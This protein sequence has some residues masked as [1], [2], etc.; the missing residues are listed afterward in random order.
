[1]PPVFQPSE[2]FQ[3]DWSEDFAILGDERAKLQVAH[4]KLSR[5][6][7]FLLRAYPLQ[8]L[9]TLFDAHVHGFKVFDGV[10]ARGLND[11]L[12]TAKDR[13]GRGK[14][15]QVN[16]RFLAMAMLHWSEHAGASI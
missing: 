4:F 10:P 7:A 15:R 8:T 9:E 11:K 13:V 16:A 5:S 3:F 1:M 6:R 12:K 14:E 2:A